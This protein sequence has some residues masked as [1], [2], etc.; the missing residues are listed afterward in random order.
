MVNCT[1]HRPGSLGWT[2]FRSLIQHINTCHLVNDEVLPASFLREHNL[3]V[4]TPCKT[5]QTAQGCPVCKGKRRNRPAPTAAVVEE[6]LPRLDNTVVTPE[7]TAKI[8]R[9]L[10]THTATIKHIPKSFRSACAYEMKSHVSG[11]CTTGELYDLFK[12][13]HSSVDAFVTALDAYAPT[14][15]PSVSQ[16]LH[17]LRD[18]RL[19][20]ASHPDVFS[21]KWWNEQ[22]SKRAWD[23]MFDQAPVRD[24]DR[25][26]CIRDALS[27]Q[28]LEICPTEALGLRLQPDEFIILLKW[29]LGLHLLPPDQYAECSSCGEPLDIFGDHLLCCRKAGLIQR[30]NAV[31]KTV[32]HHCT[33][34]GL[35]ATPEVSIDGRTRPADLLLSHWK[36]GGPCALDI[37][38]VHPLAPS[39]PFA[40]VKTG[41]EAIENMERI[42]RAKSAEGCEKSNVAFLPVVLST[43]GAIGSDGT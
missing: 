13:W 28:W 35:H 10:C 26:H 20:D 24:R 12:F 40:S 34:A 39:I 11:A 25:L 15:P 4:C 17:F 33:A 23:T 14:A 22:I 18:N 29:W 5:L 8:W 43:F 16:A 41:R 36:G 37:A 30:H 6:Q 3:S 9:I 7:L 42:K 27:A 1:C 19:T 32:W 21:L 2:A 31:V 38:V